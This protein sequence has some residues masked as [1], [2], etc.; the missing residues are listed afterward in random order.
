MLVHMDHIHHILEI[1]TDNLQ[2]LELEAAENEN[3]NE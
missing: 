2:F 1:T 3:L